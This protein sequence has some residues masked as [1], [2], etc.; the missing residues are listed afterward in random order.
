MTPILDSR[1]L[2][3]SSLR[4]SVTGPRKPHIFFNGVCWSYTCAFGLPYTTKELAVHNFCRGLLWAR[5]AAETWPTVSHEEF[6]ELY[7]CV[8]TKGVP[9]ETNS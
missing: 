2:P 6:K 3:C 9:R 7:L 5:A 8:P 4:R 1:G